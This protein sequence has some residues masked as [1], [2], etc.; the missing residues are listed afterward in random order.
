M[1]R[2]TKP[3]TPLAQRLVE[4]RGE[5]AR[6]DFSESL[7]IKIHNYTAYERGISVPS[8]EAMNL[9]AKHEGINLHWLLTGE[10]EMY[11]PDEP[12]TIPLDADLMEIVVEAV[13]EYQVKDKRFK[14]EHEKRWVIYMI[15]Y[16]KIAEIKDKYTGPEARS[17]LKQEVYD[18]LKLATL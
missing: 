11:L 12:P 10:G 13:G 1:G 14:F 18:M 2:P 3:K 6:V 9:I 16:R 15:C 8:V 5:R 4:T 7:G 17:L